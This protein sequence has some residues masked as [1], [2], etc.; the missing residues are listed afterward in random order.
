VTR[1]AL[2][3]VMF[4]REWIA[5]PRVIES[6]RIL[7]PAR[8]VAPGARP[9]ECP[10]MRV[11]VAARAVGLEPHPPDGVPARR[12]RRRRR[13]TKPRRMTR[14]AFRRG[15]ASVQCV[16]GA[17]RVVEALGRA[18]GPLNERELSARVIRVAA[19]ARASGVPACMKALSL[20]LQPRDLPMA[21]EATL[22]R[23]L[24]ASTVALRAVPGSLERCVRLRERSGRDLRAQGGWGECEATDRCPYH[25]ASRACYR[26]RP[27]VACISSRVPPPRSAIRPWSRSARRSVRASRP[28]PPHRRERPRRR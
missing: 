6:R 26:S 28:G 24:L 1:R 16:T 8:V 4:A 23:G 15:V 12:E 21:A 13:D 2:H 27:R 5:G 20:L 18:A 3:R 11:V 7:P 22:H 19:R 9:V 17:A 14:R 10:A 25:R